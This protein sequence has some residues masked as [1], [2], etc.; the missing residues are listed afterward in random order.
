MEVSEIHHPQ[1]T[2]FGI[3]FQDGG[4]CHQEQDTEMVQRCEIIETYSHDHSLE[5]S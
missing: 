2:E 5:S 3:D 4:F 1:T